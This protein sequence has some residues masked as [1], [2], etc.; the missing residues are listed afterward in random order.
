MLTLVVAVFM[1]GCRKDH[2][3]DVNELFRTLPSTASYV[4]VADLHSII[5]KSGSKVDGD[6]VVP[7]PELEKVLKQG[8]KSGKSAV[9]EAFLDGESGIEPSVMVAFA[10]GFSNYAVG[11]LSSTSRF[12]EFVTKQNGG[13]WK[14]QDGVKYNGIYAISEN[15]F[16]VNASNRDIDPDKIKE[17]L[18]LSEKQS[19][20]GGDFASM[21]QDSDRDLT[22]WCDLNGVMNT[23]GVNFQQRAMVKM[24]SEAMFKDAE[25][26]V[27]D[28]QF[29]KGALRMEGRL[30]DSKGKDAKYLLSSEKIDE[31]V[32]DRIGG[33]GDALFAM[34]VP[35]KLIKQIQ[36]MAS[37]KMSMVGVAADAMSCVDGTVA[38]AFCES[39]SVKGVVQT[40]G[41][42][43]S[44]LMGLLQQTGAQVSKEGKELLF[45]MGAMDGVESVKDM[46]SM[47]KG[48]SMGV[49][50]DASVFNG[51]QQGIKNMVF[52]MV[53]RSG[54]M[55][56]ELQVY[57]KD[58]GVNFII[59]M[60]KGIN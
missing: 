16:W 23:A 5:E 21:L 7:G 11:I 6:K 8:G 27:F 4:I 55:A 49:V 48:C 15:R 47:L 14:E 54:S 41:K 26:A 37:G 20:A 38:M 57:T 3:A 17:Y 18:A 28:M 58:S 44:D 33:K 13:E 35:Q 43:S 1:T 31:K 32:L 22:G 52:R 42:S 51:E 12:Q 30:L 25:F 56:M 10:D 40:N 29:D 60:L 34:A 59:A 9:A 36:D 39:S 45:S 2:G 53:P 24:A 46:A 19:F 50:M